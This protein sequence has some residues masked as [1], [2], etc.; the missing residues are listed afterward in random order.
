LR[1]R[2]ETRIV[3]DSGVIASAAESTAGRPPVPKLLPRATA[4]C[5]ERTTW[6]RPATV[7]PAARCAAA[8]SRQTKHA[9]ITNGSQP[10]APLGT[11]VDALV[12]C[13]SVSHD[14]PTTYARATARILHTNYSTILF[15]FFLIL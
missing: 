4:Q 15:L 10:S 3:G 7:S 2:E 8:R 14:L 1:R 5:G 12:S 11:Q 9:I 6:R 13:T